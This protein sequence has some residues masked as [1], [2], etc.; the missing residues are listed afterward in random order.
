M[1]FLF[2]N[3]RLIDCTGRP[4]VPD[5]ALLIEG[6]TI[7]D[8]GPSGEVQRRAGNDPQVI[9]VAGATVMPGLWDAHVHLGAVVPPWDEQFRGE[10]E[11]AYAFRCMRKAQDNLMAGITS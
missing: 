1:A 7:R 8:V 10:S 9:D 2:V 4:A 5:T 11:T 3:C 6:T